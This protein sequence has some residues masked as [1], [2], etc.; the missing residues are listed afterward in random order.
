M[1]KLPK[2]TLSYEYLYQMLLAP[3][4]TKLL[5]TGIE[6][7]VFNALSKPMSAE[8]VA[9]T[10]D[11]HPSNTR[12]FLNSLAAIDLLEKKEGIYRNSPIAEA[13]LVE[14]SPTFLGRLFTSMKPD[15]QVL[16]NLPQLVQ[17]GPPP[18]PEITA[19]LSSTY[20][21]RDLTPMGW[22]T[23]AAK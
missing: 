15:D 1:K 8:D 4:R 2:V 19:P 20:L 13:F 18:P 21:P 23:S 9:K 5:L 11:T 10:L 7:N 22:S 16:Q 3:I 12:A 17:E 14:A 6:L